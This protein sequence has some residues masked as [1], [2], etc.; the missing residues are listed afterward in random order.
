[1]LGTPEPRIALPLLP[2]F[3]PCTCAWRSSALMLLGGRRIVRDE[4]TNGLGVS[5]RRQRHSSM[6]R[7]WPRFRSLR[8]WAVLIAIAS[9]LLLLVCLGLLLLLLQQSLGSGDNHDGSSNTLAVMVATSQELATSYLPPSSATQ[10]NGSGVPLQ[11]ATTAIHQ[12]RQREAVSREQLFFANRTSAACFLNQPSRTHQLLQA[13]GRLDDAA[14]P[15]NA[16]FDSSALQSFKRYTNNQID[17]VSTR[18][19]RTHYVHQYLSTRIWEMIQL[20]EQQPLSATLVFEQQGVRVHESSNDQHTQFLNELQRSVT[21]TNDSSNNNRKQ[22]T[23]QQVVSDLL[24]SQEVPMVR[25]LSFQGSRG[26]ESIAPV[27]VC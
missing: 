2:S 26:Y 3:P 18:L 25:L 8:C 21:S 6:R 15:A 17:F 4:P 11:S 10:G 13:L 16:R 1:M 24:R 23:L 20:V 14:L 9:A 5:S 12:Q 22:N 19:S 7:V 27:V